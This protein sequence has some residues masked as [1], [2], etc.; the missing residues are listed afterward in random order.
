M[1]PHVFYVP[2]FA[3][4]LKLSTAQDIPCSVIQDGR[5]TCYSIPD[6]NATDCLYS[7]ANSSHYVLANQEEGVDKL[8][9]MKSDRTLATSRCLTVVIYTRDCIS[10]KRQHTGTCW[11][12]CT[13]DAKLL[14]GGGSDEPNPDT[15][16]Y[17]WI[18]PVVITVFL[19]VLVVLGFLCYW[20]Y[21]SKKKKAY[22]CPNMDDGES[23]ESV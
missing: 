7:W 9:E 5:L 15:S 8:V 16:R 17:Y 1:L 20:I 11:T 12:N 6:F 2:I 21:T 10:E 13:E 18:P 14:N 23:G 19:L 22:S 4:L 3:V